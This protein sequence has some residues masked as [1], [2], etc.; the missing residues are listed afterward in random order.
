SEDGA[1][2]PVTMVQ[3]A[4]DLWQI[5]ANSS[6]KKD[7]VSTGSGPT[8]RLQ[9]DVSSFPPVI[10]EDVSAGREGE[11]HDVSEPKG[12]WSLLACGES[13]QGTM[14]KHHHCAHQQGVPAAVK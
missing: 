14:V 1:S 9:T 8:P 11:C 2:P 10:S 12:K 13:T 4:A 3:N 5:I 6:T 7:I